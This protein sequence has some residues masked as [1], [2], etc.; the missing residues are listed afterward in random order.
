LVMYSY[1]L[2]RICFLNNNDAKIHLLKGYAVTLSKFVLPPGRVSK[3]HRSNDLIV[4]FGVIFTNF[5]IIFENMIF[6]IF[7]LYGQQVGHDCT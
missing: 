1:T 3:G 6:K 7:F 2:C 5:C 4:L